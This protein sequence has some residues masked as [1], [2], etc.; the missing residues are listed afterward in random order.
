MTNHVLL[1]NVTHQDLR[2]DTRYSASY[3]NDVGA[4]IT[5]AT[6]FADVQREYPILLQKDSQTQT[7]Q[8]VALLGLS[9]DENLFLD[10]TVP[11]HWNADYV[12]AALARGPFLIGFEDQ[13]ADGGSDNAPVVLIDMD[14]PRISNKD[15]D[16]IFL[17]HGGNS[18][19][20]ES[21][22]TILQ[23]IHQGMQINEHMINA[24]T[25]MDLIEPVTFDIE[26]DNGEKIQI[27]GNHTISQEKLA[28]LDGSQLQQLNSAGFLQG[29]FLIIASMQNM[30]KLIRLKNAQVSNA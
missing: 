23:G 1:D 10:A 4:V 15:G 27:A 11:S 3:G 29:A 30:K 19:Y 12:P 20:L 17:E 8:T 26:L 18:R 24:F 16:T 21:I 14:S 2:V 28:K 22:N 6:E 25:Q 9:V 7:F 13:S 5:F